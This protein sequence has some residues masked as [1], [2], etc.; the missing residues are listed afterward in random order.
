MLGFQLKTGSLHKTPAPPCIPTDAK[1]V[2]M[3]GKLRDWLIECEGLKLEL[4]TDSVGK[5]SIGVGRNLDDRGI[6]RKEALFLLEED[7]AICLKELEVHPWYTRQPQGVREALI[8]MCFNLGMPRLL[9]FK[10]MIAALDGGNLHQA[11]LEAL[12]SLWAKQVGQRAKDISARIR[13]GR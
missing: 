10:K 13:D 4:Y 2:V 8:N 7:V 1:G 12:D 6:S 11:S 9:T 5:K 3:H